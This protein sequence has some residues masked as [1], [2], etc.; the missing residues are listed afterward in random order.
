MRFQ[1]EWT[2]IVGR[3]RLEVKGREI[4]EAPDSS[5]AVNRIRTSILTKLGSLNSSFE[6]TGLD[7][8]GVENGVPFSGTSMLRFLRSINDEGGMQSRD[9]APNA[10]RLKDMQN[11]TVKVLQETVNVNSMQNRA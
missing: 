9:T 7:F 6:L 2:A 3:F 1:I 11:G 10:V 8:L 4:V 5:Q